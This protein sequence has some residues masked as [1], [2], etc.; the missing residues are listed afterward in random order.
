MIQ[1][2]DDEIKYDKALE[3][4][5]RI[6]EEKEKRGEL[7]EEVVDVR[8]LR[9]R[10]FRGCKKGMREKRKRTLGLGLAKRIGVAAED[11]NWDRKR[12]IKA[13]E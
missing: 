2:G 8:E 9:A 6:L 12:K 5:R 3:I 11:E 1:T 7:G 13:E 10:F 4:K